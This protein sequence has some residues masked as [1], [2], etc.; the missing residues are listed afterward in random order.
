MLLDESKF[1]DDES[2]KFGSESGSSGTYYFCAFTLNAEYSVAGV[3]ASDVFAPI[4]V[5]SKGG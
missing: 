4:G 5:K 1:L 2:E 3:S